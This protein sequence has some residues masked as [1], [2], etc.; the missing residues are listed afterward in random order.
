M[1]K[2][3]RRRALLPVV[4]LPLTVELVSV[5]IIS[6]DAAAV[7]IMPCGTVAADGGVGERQSAI[8]KNPAAVG[9]ATRGVATTDGALVDGQAA[10]GERADGTALTRRS[11]CCR[12]PT[13]QRQARER[14]VARATRN[15]KDP[16]VLLGVDRQAARKAGGVDGHRGGDIE[17][18]QAR[19][20]LD[21]PTIKGSV[22][23]NRIC[24]S[25]LFGQFQR[26]AQAQI[27]GFVVAVV[28]VQQRRN[29]RIALGD[30][31]LH[32]IGRRRRAG[33][34]GYLKRPAFRWP[35]RT[36]TETTGCRSWR[37]EG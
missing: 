29:N 30:G 18:T 4:L 12:F 5:K 23:S 28:F 32:R 1:N 26:L 21:C 3:R 13:G 22:E 31:H 8:R 27:P 16:R 10:G 7:G 15:I 14:D 19:G 20:E 37:F 35:T 34:D 6:E 33:G 36:E 17:I 25:A 24:A 2:P 9:S 11:C